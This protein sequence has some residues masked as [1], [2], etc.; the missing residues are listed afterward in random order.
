VLVLRRPELRVVFE[1]S[2]GAGESSQMMAASSSF[3]A[4]F[5]LR[6]LD[7]LSWAAFFFSAVV[8]LGLISE[9][10]TAGTIFRNECFGGMANERVRL[11]ERDGIS[12]ADLAIM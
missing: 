12:S 7:L 5:C 2:E 1:L 8:S 4:F 3:S 10:L 9:V 6:V 11:C